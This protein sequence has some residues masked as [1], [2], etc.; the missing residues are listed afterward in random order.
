MKRNDILCRCVK[1]GPINP[2]KAN[3]KLWEKVQTIV[4]MLADS[5]GATGKPGKASR[6]NDNGDSDEG[7]HKMDDETPSSSSSS[8]SSDVT[9][10]MSNGS[11]RPIKGL[12][13]LG[14]TC[15]FNSVMQNIAETLPLK[16]WLESQHDI[17]TSSP[18]ASTDLP[19][20]LQ[21]SGFMSSMWSHGSGDDG[22]DDSARTRG[23]KKKQAAKRSSSNCYH[24]GGLFNE[25]VKG[26]ATFK[27]N[28]QQDSHELLRYLIDSL[29]EE[30]DAYSKKT[31]RDQ[32]LS[33]M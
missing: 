16:Y 18:A 21:M 30:M 31:V 24:P 28:R 20:Q 14:N 13:N 9:T 8:S 5:T 7:E 19:M 10:L 22:G 27:G 26:N 6:D 23:G 12:Y 2:K 17:L 25:I 15:F 1:C 4:K 29:A 11:S 32:A 3:G 33:S